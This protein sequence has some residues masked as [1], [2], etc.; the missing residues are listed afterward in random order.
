MDDPW[1][2][3][4]HDPLKLSPRN[5]SPSFSSSK[6]ITDDQADI[7]LPS[8]DAAD[9]APAWTSATDPQDELWTGDSRTSQLWETPTLES[10]GFAKPS[11]E[12]ATTR[13]SPRPPSPHH[14]DPEQQGPPEPIVT[15][16][17]PPEEA[18]PSPVHQSLP[19]RLG[20]FGEEVAVVEE[21]AQR[22]ASPDPEGFGTFSLPLEDSWTPSHSTFPQTEETSDWG[23]TWK[24]QSE[25]ADNDVGEPVDEWELA[26][27]QKEKQ[28]R[29]VV[30]HLFTI[31]INAS[32][33][34][35]ASSRLR[36]HPP[37]LQ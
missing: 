13:D 10:I 12:P 33:V 36:L 37:Q 34:V 5:P 8:W 28:D 16:A 2:N 29:Y 24:D 32:N 18:E 15:P 7:G 23:A 25:S 20:G 19:E 27:R 6:F 30:R 9:A 11:D 1:L 35:S 3:A 21:V 31:S 4:W 17:T 26:K 14:L 22:G